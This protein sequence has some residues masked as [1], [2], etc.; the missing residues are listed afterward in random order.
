[1][2]G[3]AIYVFEGEIVGFVI[4]LKG[5]TDFISYVAICM[6]ILRGLADILEFDAR[7]SLSRTVI[8]ATSLWGYIAYPG[9]PNMSKCR[10]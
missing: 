7:N 4:F 1:V 9:K 8:V 6:E 2:H 3:S 5:L 10:E